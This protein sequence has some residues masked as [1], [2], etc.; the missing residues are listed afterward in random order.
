M[1]DQGSQLNSVIEKCVNDIW[2]EY[3]KDGN[4][5]LDKE[6]TKAF[7]KN[8]L[9]EMNDNASIEDQDF[10]DTFKEFDKDG[11]GTI[12]KDEMAAFIKKVAGIE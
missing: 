4:G 12:E 5:Y 11:S 10:E 3:D 9:S 2:Q 6:E 1:A 8:T 7:V